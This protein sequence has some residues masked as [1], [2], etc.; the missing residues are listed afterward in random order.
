MTT[1]SGEDLLWAAMCFYLQHAKP[2]AVVGAFFLHRKA[3]RQSWWTVDAQESFVAD[4]VHCPLAVQHP[5]PRVLSVSVI[6]LFMAC[7]EA[8]AALPRS[9]R[10]SPEEERGETNKRRGGGDQGG[11]AQEEEEEG[12]SLLE[13]SDALMSA[14][15]TAQCSLSQAS[16]PDDKCYKTLFFPKPFHWRCSSSV[17]EEVATLTASHGATAL[18]CGGGCLSSL[19]SRYEPC[20]I[21][22]GPQFAVLGESLWPAAAALCHWLGAGLQ[23][24]PTTGAGVRERARNDIDV[25]ARTAPPWR[26]LELG[27]GVGLTPCCVPDPHGLVARFVATDYQLPVVQKCLDNVRRNE[28]AASASRD[29]RYISADPSRFRHGVLASVTDA[30][31]LD[32]TDVVSTAKA[33]DQN[34]CVQREDDDYHHA[35][36][37]PPFVRPLP[38]RGVNRTEEEEEEEEVQEELAVGESSSELPNDADDRFDL[39]L[40]ADVVYDVDVIDGLAATLHAA[41]RPR[42]RSDSAPVAY[43]FSTVRNPQTL[44][45]FISACRREGLEATT[46]PCRAA[47]TEDERVA[48]IFKAAV[49]EVSKLLHA[50]HVLLEGG[51]RKMAD[52]TATSAPDERRQPLAD[53]NNVSETI[54]DVITGIFHVSST[55]DARPGFVGA[56]MCDMRDRLLVHRIGRGSLPHGKVRQ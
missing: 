22:V 37:P 4:V 53:G 43:V 54:D 38:I 46:V 32:W 47:E 7:C 41:L 55:V 50:G 35:S 5:P 18:P 2:A 28:K 33:T 12:D 40:A 29:E 19:G 42:P 15:T 36:P 10:I 21:R 1:A 26:V 44:A 8:V 51:G 52:R 49:D 23:S 3:R 45:Q 48:A 24:P 16:K 14:M 56:V 30:G 13:W 20:A 6:K 31:I 25:I 17:C 27:A 39:V 9:A 34:G 11:D